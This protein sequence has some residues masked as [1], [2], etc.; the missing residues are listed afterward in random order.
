[1]GWDFMGVWELEDL[2]F[3]LGFR[4]SVEQIHYMGK[5]LRAVSS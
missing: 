5:R 3:E 4:L 2:E 1:M